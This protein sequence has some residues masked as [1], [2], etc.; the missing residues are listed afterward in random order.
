MSTTSAT[1]LPVTTTGDAPD[2]AGITLGLTAALDKVTIPLF[3]S[4]SARDAAYGTGSG[5]A[6]FKLCVVGSDIAS[7]TC[8]M[9][10]GTA[11][12]Q[13]PTIP[14]SVTTGVATNGP[15]GTVTGQFMQV[16]GALR[17]IQVQATY[18][19]ADVTPSATGSF[20]AV[21]LAQLTWNPLD[22]AGYQP[23]NATTALANG[24]A[25]W[26]CQVTFDGMLHLRGG[27]P[28]VTLHKNDLITMGGVVTGP[29]S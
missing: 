28:G 10:V 1:G 15:N 5:K 19:G 21:Q 6:A 7:G 3:A 24:N 4:T 27:Y 29:A 12:Q 25:I 20:A 23:I 9:R 26:N 16:F 11:W 17:L 2:L 13:V 18:T 8:Y 22:L 14:G